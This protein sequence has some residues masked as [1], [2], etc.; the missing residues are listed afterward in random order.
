[1]TNKP[2]TPERLKLEAEALRLFRE[3]HKTHRVAQEVVAQQE[4]KKNTDKVKGSK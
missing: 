1:M 4:K 2:K 3:M